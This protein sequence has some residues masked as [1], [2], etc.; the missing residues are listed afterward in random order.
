MPYQVIFT[1]EAD[2]TFDD[3]G[4]QMFNVLPYQ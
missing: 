3:I 2:D 1:D 4:N